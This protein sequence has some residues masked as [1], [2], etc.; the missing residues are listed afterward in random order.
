MIPSHLEEKLDSVI[1]EIVADRVAD[2][3]S[4]YIENI[5]CNDECQEAVKKFISGIDSKQEIDHTAFVT[6]ISYTFRE[7]VLSGK[8]NIKVETETL[9]GKIMH[10]F[11]M[12]RDLLVD[13][14][15]WCLDNGASEKGKYRATLDVDVVDG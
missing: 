13:G 9:S 4:S 8:I 12:N 1:E 5:I 2:E 10:S 6:F 3:Y 15:G 7:L 14:L 11:D